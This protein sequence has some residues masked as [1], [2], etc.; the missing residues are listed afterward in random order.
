MPFF[1]IALIIH[2]KNKNKNLPKITFILPKTHRYIIRFTHPKKK[3]RKKKGQKRKKKFINDSVVT[4][5]R[6]ASRR[7]LRRL[8]SRGRLEAANFGSLLQSSQTQQPVSQPAS[9]RV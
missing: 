9:Q 8:R 6:H 3:K 2:C 1:L 4:C 5:G 7:Q